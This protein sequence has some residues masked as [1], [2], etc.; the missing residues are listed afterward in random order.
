MES[1]RSP[2][3]SPKRPASLDLRRLVGSVNQLRFNDNRGEVSF[4]GQ[5]M[6]ILRRDVIRVIREGLEKLVG[7]QATPFLSY[8]AS[9]IGVHEG[10]IFRESTASSGS[11]GNAGIS[12]M[13]TSALE[14][15]NLGLGKIH[16]AKS[17]FEKGTA[18]VTISNCFEALENGTSEMPNCTFTSG[19]LAGMFAEVFD[20]TVQA[21]ETR[22]MSQGQSECEFVISPVQDSP[23]EGEVEEKSGID[24]PQP[25]ASSGTTVTPQAKDDTVAKSSEQSKVENKQPAAAKESSKPSGSDGMNQSEI[26]SGLERASRIA[27]RKDRFWNKWFQKE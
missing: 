2:S 15:T 18:N 7:D 10:S 26:D 25:V 17:D 6:I 14:D 11:S 27:K 1:S 12:N 5:K 23:E 20:K 24:E 21:I 4:F 16:V 13:V 19:F 22:C 8:L 9:G 3:V